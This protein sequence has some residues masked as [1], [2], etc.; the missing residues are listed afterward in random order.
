LSCVL[1][2]YKYQ[3]KNEKYLCWVGCQDKPSVLTVS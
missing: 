1:A 3:G 2:D